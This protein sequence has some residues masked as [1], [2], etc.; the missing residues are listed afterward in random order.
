MTQ[1]VNPAEWAYGWAV[2]M[3]NVLLALLIY[4]F[5]SRKAGKAFWIW[6][7]GVNSLRALGMVAVAVVVA[8]HVVGRPLPYL[9]ALLSGVFCM[10]AAE[11]SILNRRL[12]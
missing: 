8:I 11:V 5:A 12:F 6:A 1:A 10:M 3:V 9:I 4:G 7:I 2:S